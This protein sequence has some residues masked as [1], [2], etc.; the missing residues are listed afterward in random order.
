ME[1]IS[2]MIKENRNARKIFTLIELLVVIAIIV[3]ENT[4]HDCGYSFYL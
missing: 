2:I 1:L 4:M 3:I